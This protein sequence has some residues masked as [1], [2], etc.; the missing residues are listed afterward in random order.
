MLRG[1]YDPAF[2]RQLV[3]IEH[4]HF[5]FRARN[6]LIFKLARRIACDFQPGYR[7]LEIGCGTGNVL[8]V[9]RK[10]CPGGLVVGLELWFEG[11]RY[12]QRR[13]AGLLVQ[14]DIRDYPFGKPFSLICMFDVL[15]HVHEEQ[16][17]LA[18]IWKNLVPDGRLFL[19][20][21]AHQFL[22]SHFDE[23]AHHCRRYSVR[24]IQKKVTAAGFHVEFVSQFMA[25]IFPV[26]WLVR[27]KRG[28]LA[29]ADSHTTNS[30]TT[31][32]FKL[33]PVLNQILTALL[34][35]EAGWVVRGHRLPFGTSIV[36]VA[37]KPA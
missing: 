8:P 10:A 19:T 26:V 23:A 20:V 1:G 15:E 11:L 7:V 27:K 12:A 36:V 17:T 4:E 6:Q 29:Q 32:E 25:S 3:R 37:R 28:L 2:F 33:V 5:W 30:R 13:S 14:G 21:P 35:L 18:S 9:L 24:E 22:W 34:S 31:D 16:E